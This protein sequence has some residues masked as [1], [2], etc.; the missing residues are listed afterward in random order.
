MDDF[1][2]RDLAVRSECN[3]NTLPGAV[4]VEAFQRRYHA[5]VTI[6]VRSPCGTAPIIAAPRI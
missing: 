2:F 3:S 4:T 5:A 1:A 6:A